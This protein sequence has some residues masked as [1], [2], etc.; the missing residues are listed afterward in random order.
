MEVEIKNAEL[1]ATL[2]IGILNSAIIESMIKD[3]IDICK[4]A[5]EQEIE[6]CI[7]MLSDISK[8][9][10]INE[11]ETWNKN[12]VNVN[13]QAIV[14]FRKEPETYLDKLIVNEYSS[15]D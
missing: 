15:R 1:Y 7:N 6:K 14:R 10:E 11:M 12:T 9:I 2:R 13:V 8:V 4:N 3:G 5:T